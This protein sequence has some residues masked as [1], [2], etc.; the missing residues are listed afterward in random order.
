MTGNVAP[1]LPP[2]PRN[3]K[4]QKKEAEAAEVRAWGF[5]FGGGKLV[6]LVSIIPLSGFVTHCHKLQLWCRDLL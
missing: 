3:K 4:S 1:P 6:V 2:T 5:F